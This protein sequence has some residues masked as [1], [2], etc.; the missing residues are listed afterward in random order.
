[1]DESFWILAWGVVSF[2]SREFDKL[3]SHSSMLLHIS[4]FLCAFPAIP[5]SCN[6]VRGSACGLGCVVL[7]LSQP[8]HAAAGQIFSTQIF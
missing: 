2:H 5:I 8:A 3:N 4:I 7:A 6:C 1:V